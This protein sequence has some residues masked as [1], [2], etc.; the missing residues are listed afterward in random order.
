M[1]GNFNRIRLVGI[2][3]AGVGGLTIAAIGLFSLFN[4][5]KLDAKLRSQG[6]EATGTV[7]EIKRTSTVI[8]TGTTAYTV[9]RCSYTFNFKTQE[10]QALQ[11]SESC[12]NQTIRE[13]QRIPIRYIR[14]EANSYHVKHANSLL[15][16]SF[17][18]NSLL[19]LSVVLLI[20]FS[21]LGAIF[22]SD[23][24]LLTPLNK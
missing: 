2:R 7:T 11:S 13:G 14:D 22:L 15:S 18:L 19:I 3:A 24:E 6:V 5:N 21:S 8:A 9:H 16:Q 10:G 17:N 23:E 20:G 1:V 4:G 12:N